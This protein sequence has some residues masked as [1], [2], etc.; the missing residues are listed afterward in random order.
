LQLPFSRGRFP[1]VAEGIALFYQ[2][3]FTGNLSDLV[4]LF[5]TFKLGVKK[6]YPRNLLAES[7]KVPS[8]LNHWTA[9]ILHDN[10]RKAI[11]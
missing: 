10:F 4:V 11:G 9:T 5:K 1:P 2:P 3:A 8:L 7:S 6:V